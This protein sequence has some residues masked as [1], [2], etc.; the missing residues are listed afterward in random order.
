[1]RLRLIAIVIVVVTVLGGAWV[2]RDLVANGSGGGW[3]HEA[4]EAFD[5]ERVLFS[6]FERGRPNLT[7]LVQARIGDIDS[8]E[9]ESAV[10]DFVGRLE[11]RPD[12]SQIESY[13]SLGRPEWMRSDDGQL[14]II[15][16]KVGG[17]SETYANRAANLTPLL[18][19]VDDAVRI[20]MG[21]EVVI[22]RDIQG[23][24][25][26]SIAPIAIMALLSLAL[27]FL[28]L[29]NPVALGL[30]ATAS[31]LA[32]SLTL[33][34]L[35]GLAQFREMPVAAVVLGV[36]SEGGLAAFAPDVATEEG[37]AV[38]AL[39]MLMSPVEGAGDLPLGEGEAV[40]L[41]PLK[42]EPG[43]RSHIKLVH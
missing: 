20:T 33:L 36:I 7:F 11:Q 24:L 16:A 41:K 13:W 10:V 25:Q 39:Y 28:A 23:A 22:H 37:R 30:V 19:T 21:G 2:G 18:R 27:V 8:P 42:P 15:H 43:D 34:G 4:G 38:L 9:V 29:R 3:S 17:T 31:L 26:D 12:V 1:V 40:A 5:A 35:Y 14:A 32:V 6:T